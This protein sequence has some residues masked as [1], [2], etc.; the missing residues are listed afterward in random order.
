M[1]QEICTV[2]DS[3]YKLGKLLPDTVVGEEGSRRTSVSLDATPISTDPCMAQSEVLRSQ[4]DHTH[5]T[6]CS[7]ATCAWCPAWSASCCLH[8]C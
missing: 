1:Q 7:L 3:C 8:Y 4:E 6:G 5:H 2:S